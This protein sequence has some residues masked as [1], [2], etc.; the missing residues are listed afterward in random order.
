M[1][2]ISKLQKN[3]PDGLDGI[4]ISSEISQRYLTGF[5]YTDGYVVV[6]REKAFMLADFRYIEAAKKFESDELQIVMLK[7]AV[8]DLTR[9][10]HENSLKNVGYEDNIVVCSKYA[11][12]CKDFSEVVEFYPIGE[13]LDSMREVKDEIEVEKITRAQ[14]IAEAGF[15]HMLNFIKPDMTEREVALELEFFMRK[16]GAEASAFDVIAVS[17]TASSMPHGVPRD[18]KLEKGFLTLDFGAV[19]DG[20]LS[21]M[22]RTIVIGKADDEMKRVYNTVLEAQ[23]A[24]LDYVS[25]GKSGYDCDKVAR[26][27]IDKAGFGECFGHGLGHGVGM[28]IHEAPRVSPVNKNNLNVGNIVTVEPGIYLEGKYGVRI[29]DMVYL[30]ETGCINLTKSPKELIEL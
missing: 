1:S 7:S 23:L 3:I 6:T 16:N 14:R 12:M 2:K 13:L 30:T 10:F 24:A 29:E 11:K 18:V 20:Y 15:E 19:V 9:I 17:G 8:I 21:D 27:I 25:A 22:T 28:Y 5:N 26:D 4:L